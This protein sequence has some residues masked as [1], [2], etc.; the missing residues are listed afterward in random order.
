MEILMKII[1]DSGCE[2]CK[3]DP[4]KGEGF[5]YYPSYGIKIKNGLIVCTRCETPINAGLEIEEDRF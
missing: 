3:E 4:E 1:A 2:A 5:P